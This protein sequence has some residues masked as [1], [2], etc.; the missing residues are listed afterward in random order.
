MKVLY[1]CAANI[2]RSQM[3]EA[4]HNF[5]SNSKTAG[6]AGILTAVE[7]IESNLEDI[8]RARNIIRIMDEEDIDISKHKVKLLTDEMIKEFD[9]IIIMTG[10]KYLINNKFSKSLEYLDIEDP[11]VRKIEHIRE[12]RDQIKTRVKSLL[13]NITESGNSKTIKKSSLNEICFVD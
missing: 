13:E 6:S 3:A 7:E 12:V 10:T 4:Y 2:G 8:D 5:L 9:K 1:V 11:K